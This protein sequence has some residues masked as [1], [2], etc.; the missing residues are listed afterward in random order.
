VTEGQSENYQ[1]QRA[2]LQMV[3]PDGLTRF[4]SPERRFYPV[5]GSQTTNTAIS[6]TGFADLYAA[7]GDPDTKGGWV[8]RLYFNPLV[9]WIWFG[10]ILAALGGMIALVERKAARRTVSVPADATVQ[11]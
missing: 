6:T 3:S 5:A 7:L 9:P 4:M 8:V 10:A 11:P 1:W 2:R